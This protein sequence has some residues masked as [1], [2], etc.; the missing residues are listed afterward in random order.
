MPGTCL[1]SPRTVRRTERLRAPRG[2]PK[3]AP[4]HL[5]LRL[6]AHACELRWGAE[7]VEGRT[8]SCL[9]GVEGR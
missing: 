2:L 8:G 9:D 3:R 6:C 4:E 5:R 7:G 1:P